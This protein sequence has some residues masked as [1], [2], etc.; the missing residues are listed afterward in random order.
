MRDKEY[1]SE[2]RNDYYDEEDHFYRID[3]WK[4]G[5]DNEDGKVIAVVH[6]PSADVYYIEPEAMSSPMAQEA[7][8]ERVEAIKLELSDF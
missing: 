6:Y 4:T 1:Y 3:A 7:I 5:D 2:V 8:K